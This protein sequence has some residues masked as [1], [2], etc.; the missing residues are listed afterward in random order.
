MGLAVELLG[1]Q[2]VSNVFERALADLTDKAVPMYWPAWTGQRVV[3][4]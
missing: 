4:K 3:E 1:Y 2:E